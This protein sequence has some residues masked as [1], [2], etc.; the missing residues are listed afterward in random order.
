MKA[1][2]S[3]IVC[4]KTRDAIANKEKSDGNQ[5]DFSEQKSEL[6]PHQFNLSYNK[7]KTNMI[8]QNFQCYHDAFNAEWYIY[9][10]FTVYNFVCDIKFN[11]IE[12]IILMFF[13]IFLVRFLKLDMILSELRQRSL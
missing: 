5:S 4:L 8:R 11:H 7:D 10:K 1:E 9:W 13:L 3:S 2:S 6:I 12:N